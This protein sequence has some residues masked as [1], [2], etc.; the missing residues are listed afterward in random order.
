MKLQFVPVKA[1]K[2]H[3]NRHLLTVELGTL[4]P[5]PVQVSYLNVMDSGAVAGNH[6]HERKLEAMRAVTGRFQVELLNV[7]TG[8]RATVFLDA[9]PGSP[10]CHCL[11]LPPGIAHAVRNVSDLVAVLEVFANEPPRLADDDFPCEVLSLEGT[12]R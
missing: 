4:F 5:V 2:R 11:I 8:E 6:R 7:K 12:E 1:D 3:Q 10:D 9:V